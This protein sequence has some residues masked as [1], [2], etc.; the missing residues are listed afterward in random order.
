LCNEGGEIEL[1]SISVGA[2]GQAYAKRCESFVEEFSDG[3]SSWE[4][5]CRSPRVNRSF[6]EG[7]AGFLWSLFA[8]IRGMG[9][10][11]ALKGLMPQL[12]SSGNLPYK[13]YFSQWIHCPIPVLEKLSKLHAD[14]ENDRS[15]T[16]GKKS[17]FAPLFRFLDGQDEQNGVHRAEAGRFVLI[18][19]EGCGFMA[20][21]KKKLLGEGARLLGDLNELV[22]PHIDTTSRPRH[23]IHQIAQ[24]CW[25]QLQNGLSQSTLAFEEYTSFMDR[26]KEDRKKHLVRWM[27]LLTRPSEGVMPQLQEIQLFLEIHTHWTGMNQRN[28]VNG[29]KSHGEFIK[30]QEA[31]QGRLDSRLQGL[32]TLTRKLENEMESQ[33]N[34][35]RGFRLL[36]ESILDLLETCAQ[37]R[38]S[39]PASLETLVNRSKRD[40]QR[41]LNRFQNYHKSQLSRFKNWSPIAL[42]RYHYL[43]MECIRVF[44]RSNDKEIRCWSYCLP[45]HYRALEKELG[46]VGKERLAPLKVMVEELIA[47]TAKVLRKKTKD[48]S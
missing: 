15:K 43:E 7:D 32:M 41:V 44:Y 2:G 46:E 6:F 13:D 23:D 21:L 1:Q 40:I 5:K 20:E 9:L 45:Y 4:K 24:G 12:D 35:N 30:H 22:A 16:V 38:K 37:C 48:L 26:L 29:L 3:F 34:L 14:L 18:L 42:K 19:A 8:S 25:D 10:G 33:V 28:E 47:S 31:F 11:G 17:A 39:L 27:I 36:L